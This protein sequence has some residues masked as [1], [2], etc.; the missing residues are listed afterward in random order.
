MFYCFLW[1][2]RSFVPE[3]ILVVVY[4]TL[5]AE[6]WNLLIELNIKYKTGAPKV[7]QICMMD[8][9]VYQVLIWDNKFFICRRCNSRILSYVEKLQTASSKRVES[10]DGMC[11]LFVIGWN[12]VSTVVLSLFMLLDWDMHVLNQLTTLKMNSV[13]HVQCL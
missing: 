2:Y 1:I 8:V 3:F 9:V 11:E 5:C 10:A 7:N 12:S 13:Q 4:K 6:K